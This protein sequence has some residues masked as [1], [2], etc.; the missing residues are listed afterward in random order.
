MA[1]NVQTSS[2]ALEAGFLSQADL[3]RLLSLNAAIEA[4]RMGAAGARFA[5]AAGFSGDLLRRAVASSEE[6]ATRVRETLGDCMLHGR[7]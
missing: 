5:A 2:A 1:S 6:V 4:P 7:T 3:A